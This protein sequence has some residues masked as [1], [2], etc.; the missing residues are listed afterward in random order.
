MRGTAP[1]K[2]YRIEPDSGV[3]VDD[4]WPGW[5]DDLPAGRAEGYLS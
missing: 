3:P 2:D 4:G 1:N 5:N